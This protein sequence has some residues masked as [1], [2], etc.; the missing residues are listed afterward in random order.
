MIMSLRNSDLHSKTLSQAAKRVGKLP[1]RVEEL[2]S[3]MLWWREK[4]ALLSN[5][6][7]FPYLSTLPILL[8]KINN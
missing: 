6:Q 7:E 1:N 4:Y 5:K 8:N 2:E 3:F